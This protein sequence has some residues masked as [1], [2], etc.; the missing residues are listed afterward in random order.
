MCLAGT[1]GI[2]RSK[3][4]SWSLAPFGHSCVPMHSDFVGRACSPTYIPPGKS[5]FF[6]PLDGNRPKS[7]GAPQAGPI[8]EAQS[9]LPSGSRKQA[10]QKGLIAFL[11]AD[12]RTALARAAKLQS[13]RRG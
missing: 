4:A 6:L 2:T 5:V 3:G 13:L 1:N 11:A 12:A 8:R 7:L 9:W 10:A